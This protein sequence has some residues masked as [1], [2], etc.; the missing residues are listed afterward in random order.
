[1]S[2]LAEDVLCLCVLFN[3]CVCSKIRRE[4]GTFLPSIRTE[5]QLNRL[6]R[7][8]EDRNILQTVN[9]KEG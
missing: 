6:H 3:M 9:K 8:K 5:Y 4:M 7:V 1:M 2:S